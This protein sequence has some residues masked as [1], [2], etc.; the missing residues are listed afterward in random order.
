[1][2]YPI[3]V[4][5]S[6][7]LRA[8]AEPLDIENTSKEEIQTLAADMF[9]TMKNADGVGL[10]GPQIGISKRILV[11][12]GSDLTDTYAE[13][14]N[15]KRVMINPV[16]TEH[17]DKT[18]SYSEGCLSVPDIHCDITR[19][20]SMTVEYYDENL[21]K[22]L[23]KFDGF[24]CRMVQHEMDHLDGKMFVDHAS[25]IRKKMIASKLHNISAGKIRTQYK[26]KLS[27]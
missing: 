25:P 20:E 12:D 17:S 21:E 16:I 10:A 9:A 7:V 15:F 26:S 22:K 3:Y 4:Y 14:R 23:E 24:G 27:K 8:V 6:P 1:M 5:G 18:C 11:V 2:I 19:V 13:L